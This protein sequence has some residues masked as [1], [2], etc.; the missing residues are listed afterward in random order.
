MRLEPI[1]TDIDMHEV[2]RRLVFVG[3]SLAS[4]GVRSLLSRQLKHL[5]NQSTSSAR[6]FPQ[7]NA[8]RRLLPR[9]LRRFGAIDKRERRGVVRSR[10]GGC[11]KERRESFSHLWEKVA[12]RSE[13]G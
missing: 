2:L 11:E 4:H 9:S 13:V 7:A 3:R 8:K 12:S 6:S 1:F 10:E 5:A